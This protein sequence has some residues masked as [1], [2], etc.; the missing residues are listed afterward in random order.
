MACGLRVSFT[1]ARKLRSWSAR[2]FFFSSSASEL[3]P[4]AAKKCL[5]QEIVQRHGEEALQLDLHMAVTIAMDKLDERPSNGH[6]S[7][8]N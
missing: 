6:R 2:G 5:H 4:T 7:A 8:G 1:E 3:S